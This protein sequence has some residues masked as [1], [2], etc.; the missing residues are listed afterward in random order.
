MAAQVDIRD[1]FESVRRL[2]IGVEHFPCY[3]HRGHNLHSLD[4]VLMSFIV[5]GRGVHIIDEETFEEEGPSLAV[6]HFGQVHSIRTDARG[7][8]IYNIYLDPREGALPRMPR[9][10]HAVLPRLLPMDPRFVHRRNRVV[11]LAFDD[12]APFVHPLGA[13]IDEL[14]RRPIGFEEMVRL[15]FKAFLVRCCRHMLGHGVAGDHPPGHI[16]RVRLH[17]DH[18]F[19]G[20][21]SLE[22]LA[23]R[24]GVTRT[25]LCRAFKRETG[26]TISRYLLERRLQAALVRLRGS[27]DKILAVALDCG[28][29][30]LAYFNRAFKRI[31]GMTPTAYRRTATGGG[32]SSRRP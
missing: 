13:I 17:L 2:G 24:A 22:A 19:A 18:D 16:E 11:R 20:P 7:M 10:L 21:Q 31:I 5:S 3:V 12:P 27:D 26:K 6:T 1:R 14:D 9:E 28:F 29:R 15:H 4:A 23:A 25:S 30:D 32:S 8:E